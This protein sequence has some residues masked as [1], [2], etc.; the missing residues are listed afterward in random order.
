M[1]PAESV[2]V[3][4]LFWYVP[5]FNSSNIM[6]LFPFSASVVDVKGKLEL[7]V[8]ASVVLNV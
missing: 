6:V 8:P 3:I 5:S 1:L 2:T 4:V 7:M